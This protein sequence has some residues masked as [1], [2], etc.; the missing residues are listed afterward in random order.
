MHEKKIQTNKEL[1]ILAA[2]LEINI[3]FDCSKKE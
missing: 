3:E 1:K 2:F